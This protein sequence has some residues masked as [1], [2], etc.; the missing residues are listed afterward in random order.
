MKTTAMAINQYFNATAKA[1]VKY[2]QTAAPKK[3]VTTTL[4][5]KEVKKP[6]PLKNAS[7]I[8][9]PKKVVP[10]VKLES[11]T[12]ATVKPRKNAT[13]SKL[14]TIA[15]RHLRKALAARGV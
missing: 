5:K 4:P 1:A 2:G 15:A 3:N 8:V 12:Y 13:E 14:N 11:G 10:S 7:A 9:A 6:V